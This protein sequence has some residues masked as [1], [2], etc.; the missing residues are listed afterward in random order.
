M[1]RTNKAL[2]TNKQ[3]DRWLTNGW[4]FTTVDYTHVNESNT[5]GR[6]VEGLRWVEAIKKMRIS[7]LFSLSLSLSGLY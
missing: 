6:F 2:K 4:L 1:L 3:T 5:N 7:M